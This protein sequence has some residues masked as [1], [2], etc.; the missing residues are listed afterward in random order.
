MENLFNKI[1][2]TIFKK[3]DLIVI[4]LKGHLLIEEQLDLIINNFLPNP[5]AVNSAK[6]SFFKKTALAQ[7]ICWRR[8][9]DEIW[10]LIYSINSLR[11][12]FAHNLSSENREEKINEVVRLHA[13]MSINDPDY[14]NFIKC[15]NKDQLIYAIVHVLGFLEN[16]RKDVE[17]NCHV[18]HKVLQRQESL[19]NELNEQKQNKS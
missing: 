8:P 10:S 16:F 12:N 18:W 3:D 7:A 1:K 4:V 14:K 2:N 17:S 9:N 19:I 6:F 11:N 5:N 15:S 13:N